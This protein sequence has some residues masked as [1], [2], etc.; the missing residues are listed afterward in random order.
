[1]TIHQDPELVLTLQRVIEFIGTFAFALSGIRL[2][3]SKHYDWLGE[4]AIEGFL[5]SGDIEQ[6]QSE[7]IEK[8]PRVV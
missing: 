1:M 2:A 5:D 4:T 7:G 6:C 3:A 8:K